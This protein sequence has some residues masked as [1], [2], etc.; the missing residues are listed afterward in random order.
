MN[1]SYSIP[2][3]TAPRLPTQEDILL[4]NSSSV[5]L[6]LEAWP[7]GGCPLHYFIAEY[8]SRGQK[9]WTLVS[10]NIQQEELV[11]PDLIP[12]TWYRV[13]VAAHSDAG[14]SV[15]EFVFATKTR[16]GGRYQCSR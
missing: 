12:A 3:S 14:S 9:T 8:R 11:I 6:L 2:L 16:S 7:S 1:A 4:I 10:N 15:Q 13:R 5:N